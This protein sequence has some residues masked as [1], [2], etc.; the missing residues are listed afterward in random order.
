MDLTDWQ[1]VKMGRPELTSSFGMVRLLMC[2]Q[3][4]HT[5]WRLVIESESKLPAAVVGGRRMMREEG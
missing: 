5:R 3:K 4:D 2:P 1:A